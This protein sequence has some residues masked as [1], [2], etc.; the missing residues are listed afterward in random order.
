MEKTQ[1]NKANSRIE[2]EDRVLDLQI[3]ILPMIIF[4]AQ[5]FPMIHA[6]TKSVVKLSVV[7]LS[8]V[9][10][11]VLVGGLAFSG[12]N[13]EPAQSGASANSSQ[14][15]DA[16]NAAASV[17]QE[18]ENRPS[19]RSLL[20][21]H[22]RNSWME[23]VSMPRQLK[24]DGFA[25][26]NINVW[27]KGK[28]P[29]KRIN[30]VR[31]FQKVREKLMHLIVVSDDL[32][33]FRHIFPDHKG[34]GLF[35]TEQTLARGGAYRIYADYT[36]L[37]GVKEVA[38][39]KLRVLDSPLVNA[40]RARAPLVADRFE[41]GSATKRV[42][43][44]DENSTQNENQTSNDGEKYR[45]KLTIP[46]PIVARRGVELRFDIADDKGANLTDLQP[47]LGAMGYATVL[48]Q[49]GEI[50]LNP[51]P[52][53]VFENATAASAIPGD[54]GDIFGED[55][56]ADTRRGGPDVVFQAIFPAPGL[57]KIWGEFRHRNRVLIA[58]FVLRVA[59]KAK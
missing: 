49:D 12:C 13:R 37:D 10:L 39:H 2:S 1:P 50:Y 56:D 54:A 36:P 24:A 52:E 23:M 45:I 46:T 29:T 51:Q 22:T 18:R 26:W 25:I 30:R 55:Q 19:A 27:Q 48:S 53:D 40:S 58:P 17:R 33:F 28:A 15:A 47:Y 8:V 11:A 57:Y 21:L 59:P 9:A 4:R 7:K 5:P 38:Q 31:D 14:N 35:I 34:D 44:L 3:A 42:I 41:N 32:S 20:G 43:S 6:I 16:Q